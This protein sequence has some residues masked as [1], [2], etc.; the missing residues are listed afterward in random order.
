[1]NAQLVTLLDQEPSSKDRNVLRIT[2]LEMIKG[3][4]NHAYDDVLEIPI[5]DN[6]KSENL[7]AP[8]MEI[9]IKKYPKCNA[10]LVRRHGVY[11]WGDSWEEAKTRLESFDYLFESAL[12]MKSM[13][14]DCGQIPLM[15][16]EENEAKKRKIN[17]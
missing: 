7:L 2:H 3:V 6:Q 16:N 4:G 5:I 11:V 13:G 9:A 17:D 14:I 8:D 1:M 15:K 10:V 12:K